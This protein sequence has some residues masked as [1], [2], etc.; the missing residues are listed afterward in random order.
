[1]VL[2]GA[3]LASSC[4][5]ITEI[6]WLLSAGGS[7]NCERPESRDERYRLS[8]RYALISRPFGITEKE[9]EGRGEK[10]SRKIAV[11]K[12]AT[13]AVNLMTSNGGRTE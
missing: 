7:A 10:K 12:E 9:V 13:D 4:I 6:S 11:T 5:P 3:A 8:L 1:M 2:L